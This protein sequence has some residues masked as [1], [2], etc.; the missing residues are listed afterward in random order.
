MI[1]RLQPF[2]HQSPFNSILLKGPLSSAS[3]LTRIRRHG[4]GVAVNET[5]E[6]VDLPIQTFNQVFRLARACE[7]MIFAREEHQLRRHAVMLQRAKPLL[8]LLKRH[9]KIIVDRKST[10]LNSSHEW[11]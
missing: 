9:A 8:A 7:V 2:L 10:R 11:I 3:N 6:P 5:I 4:C 1:M